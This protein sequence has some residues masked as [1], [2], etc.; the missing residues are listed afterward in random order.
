IACISSTKH[1][2]GLGGGAIVFYDLALP[3]GLLFRHILGNE[4]IDDFSQ[5]RPCGSKAKLD[6]FK[7]S[8]FSPRK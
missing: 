4:E 3:Y 7:E 6:E 8:M 1:N 2:L 5:F